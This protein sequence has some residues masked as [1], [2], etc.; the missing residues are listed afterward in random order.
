MA[1][2]ELA[3]GIAS[4]SGVLRNPNNPKRGLVFKT[5]KSG[6]TRV[7]SYEKP[8]YREPTDRELALRRRFTFF[9]NCYQARVLRGDKRRKKDI[10][11]ELKSIYGDK[12]ITTAMLKGAIKEVNDLKRVNSK[13]PYESPDRK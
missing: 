11:A 2:V 6:K 1:K 12:E 9:S 10:Y 5:F 8:E 4:I 3:K 7:Y 13:Y